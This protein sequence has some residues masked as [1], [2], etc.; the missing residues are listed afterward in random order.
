M[1]ATGGTGIGAAAGTT[2]SAG[3]TDTMGGAT[4]LGGTT[5]TT[6]L[7]GVFVPTGSRTK[8]RQEHTATLLPNGKV[9]IVGGIFDYTTP[10]GTAELY[11]PE[12]G[13]FTATGT[14]TSVRFEHT[15]TLLSNGKILIVGGNEY[16]FLTTAELYE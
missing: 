2:G 10:L 6:V 8:G 9:L 11:D 12:G 15:A 16:P 7:Q 1:F 5:G 13:T 3:T 14:L 4:S